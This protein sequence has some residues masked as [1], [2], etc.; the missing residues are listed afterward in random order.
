MPGFSSFGTFV[1]REAASSRFQMASFEETWNE[2]LHKPLTGALQEKGRG[3]TTLPFASITWSRF[4][5]SAATLGAALSAFYVEQQVRVRVGSPC[6]TKARAADC[7][8]Q[9]CDLL[10]FTHGKVEFPKS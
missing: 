7:S 3:R 5:G 8:R 1:P 10:D 9:G 4:N 2:I 6:S